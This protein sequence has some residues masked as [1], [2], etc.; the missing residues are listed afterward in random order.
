[1]WLGSY[2]NYDGIITHEGSSPTHVQDGKQTNTCDDADCYNEG[3]M[4]V[5]FGYNPATNDYDPVDG[6]LY[7]DYTQK[8]SQTNNCNTEAD[9]YNYAEVYYSAFSEDGATVTS[10]SNQQV[11]QKNTCSYGASCANLGYV[12]NN[13]YAEDT[14]KLTATTNQVLSQ[15]C[16][17][18]GGN[19]LNDN[20]VTT[21][22]SAINNAVLS[23]TA[24]QNIN[25]FDS[26]PAEIDIQRS[27]GTTNLG[28]ITQTSG[29]T[30]TP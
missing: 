4:Y 8:L 20:T 25:Q 27:S 15:S 12:Y 23:Y 16:N 2:S 9:C 24:N 6:K 18:S 3:Y 13:V 19:C 21:S 26:S 11:T 10:V 28:T 22:G 7:T 5:S 29:G 14:A 30:I 1:M 17:I